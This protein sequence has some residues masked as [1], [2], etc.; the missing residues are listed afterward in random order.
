MEIGVYFINIA[1]ERG[2]IDEGVIGQFREGGVVF[3]LDP[4]DNTHGL[5]C[6]L[7]DSSL[8]EWGCYGTDLPNVPNV[9]S[10]PPSGL[11]AEI[12]DGINNTNN[13]LIDCPSAPAALAARSL[14]PEWFL[15]SINELREM[16][17]NKSTLEA[18]PGF[19]A[20][21]DFYWSSTEYDSISAWA[22]ELSIGYQNYYYENE[23]HVVRAVRAF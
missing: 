7:S 2:T 5:V 9:T 18:V 23:T 22:R 20:F 10:F 8:Q 3:W 16:Y 4:A 11:G 1:T 19:S 13:I 14:G 12:G 6:A 15:P 21:Y 17:V